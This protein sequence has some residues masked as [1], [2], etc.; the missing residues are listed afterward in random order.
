MIDKNP[1]SPKFLDKDEPC[2]PELRRSC[3]NVNRDLRTNGI[4]MP[5]SRYHAQKRETLLLALMID[6][7]QRLLCLCRCKC[8][9]F[10]S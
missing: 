6:F 8:I 2:F 5:C 3:D 1:D 7:T 4:G 10:P 9:I